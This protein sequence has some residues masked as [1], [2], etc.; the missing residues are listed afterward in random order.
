MYHSPCSIL[1]TAGAG[2]LIRIFWPRRH[3]MNNFKSDTRIHVGARIMC[4]AVLVFCSMNLFAADDVGVT[5]TITTNLPAGL[6]ITRQCFT[7]GGQTNLVSFTHRVNG[8]VV[9]R[10]H[11]FYYLG[12]H[13]ADCLIKPGSGKSFVDSY[14][15]FELHFGF[16]S[17]L[18]TEATICE[19]KRRVLDRFAVTNGVLTPVATSELIYRYR[20]PAEA[21][22]ELHNETDQ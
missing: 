1:Y 11:R 4:W 10:L 5:A 7:R 9:E 19:E 16:V 21:K 12:N 15:G 22:A 6:I 13:A 14:N 3:A 18:L 20:I 17:N 8:V 2:E